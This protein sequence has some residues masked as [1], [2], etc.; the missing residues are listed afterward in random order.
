MQLDLPVGGGVGWAVG[1]AVEGAVGVKV[2]SWGPWVAPTMK[3]ENKPKKK[4]THL[5]GHWKW[6]Y[7]H[8]VSKGLTVN[9]QKRQFLP[10]TVQNADQY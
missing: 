10:L 4:F 5:K 7:T 9:S 3:F 8:R 2:V 1:G 6:N